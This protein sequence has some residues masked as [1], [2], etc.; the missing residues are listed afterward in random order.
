VTLLFKIILK[1]FN[2]FSENKPG[3]VH[4]SIHV[5]IHV[6]IHDKYVKETSTVD[7]TFGGTSQIKLRH[8]SV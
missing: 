1:Y 6:F 3:S 4:V 8:G 2:V 5:S 7:V